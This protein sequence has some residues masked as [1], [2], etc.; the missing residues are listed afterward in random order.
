MRLRRGETVPC[1][2][3]PWHRLRVCRRARNDHLRHPRGAPERFRA[4]TPTRKL[5]RFAAGAQIITGVELIAC[6]AQTAAQPIRWRK[7]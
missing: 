3:N 4:R 6:L 2:K 5:E 7:R 1:L